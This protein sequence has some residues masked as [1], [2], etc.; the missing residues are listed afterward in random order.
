MQPTLQQ[1]T[2]GSSLS[3]WFINPLIGKLSKINE[4]SQDSVTYGGIAAKCLGFMAS[5]FAGAV[6]AL[7]LQALDPMILNA[8]ADITYMSPVAIVLGLLSLA[9]FLLMP[10]LAF[11][12]KATIPV[13][14]TLYC[15]STGYIFAFLSVVAQEYRGAILLAM[16]LTTVIVA[17]MALIYAKG[18]IKVDQKF[19][20]VMSILFWTT[21]ASSL[22]VGVC[23]FIPALK[24]V[25]ELIAQHPVVSL[26]GSLLYVVIASL[27]LLVDFDTIK[28][29]A[30]RK[31]P[32]K[33]EWY[34]A[35]GLAFSVIWLFLK[36]FN[37]IS[38]A[39]SSSK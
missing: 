20:S 32:R 18:W 27:F 17:M 8:D 35:F 37:L 12:I 19:R 3:T 28:Q 22:L 7:L 14:G 1:P 39:K 23:Y 13:T 26:L 10:F 4:V 29:A 24:C 6:I 25:P 15:A 38:K 31:L 2:A 5:I 33:Y 21:V 34:A 16:I 11:L 9:F 30:E 36:L